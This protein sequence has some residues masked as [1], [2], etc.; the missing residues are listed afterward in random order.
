GRLAQGAAQY[1]MALALDARRA[2]ARLKLG[3]ALEQ[4]G[5]LAAA[6]A[7]Y[8]EVLRL[9]PENAGARAAVEAARQRTGGVSP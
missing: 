1:R 8:R 3:L 4:Q 7:E 5:D 2:S 9:D 6:I